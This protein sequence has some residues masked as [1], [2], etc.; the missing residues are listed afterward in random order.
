MFE[1]FS[2]R[3]IKVVIEACREAGQRGEDSV[4]VNDLFF[5]LITEDQDPTSLELN[6]R[7]P[8]V[9]SFLETKSKPVAV[10]LP[11]AYWKKR[12][13]FFPA[14]VAVSLLAKLQQIHPQADRIPHTAEMRMSSEFETAIHAAKQL[15]HEFQGGRCPASAGNGESVHPLR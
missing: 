4:G 12:E 8:H 11:L 13:P 14:E 1:T 7:D 10:L 3:A 6:D 15:Q 2:R 9:K 5:G